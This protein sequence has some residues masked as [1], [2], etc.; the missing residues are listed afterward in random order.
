MAFNQRPWA[1]HEINRLIEM[2]ANGVDNVGMAHVLDRT[3]GSVGSAIHRYVRRRPAR[4]SV[5]WNSANL[6]RLAEFYVDDRLTPTEIA[7][8]MGCTAREV[9]SLIR[10]HGIVRDQPAKESKTRPCMV[11]RRPFWS[12][13][14]GQRICRS[15]KRSEAFTCAMI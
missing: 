9:R 1:Y 2:H 8:T 10:S 14:F 6:A 15:C 3:A 13:G 7:M 11:C 4:K 12:A 5:T